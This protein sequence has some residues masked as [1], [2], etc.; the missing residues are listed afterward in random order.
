MWSI[1]NLM[2]RVSS[3][4]SYAVGNNHTI[5]NLMGRLSPSHIAMQLVTSSESLILWGVWVFL[6]NQAA[7]NEAQILNL[8]FVQPPNFPNHHDRVLFYHWHF[9]TSLLQIFTWRIDHLSCLCAFC[10]PTVNSLLK[11][12]K[13]TQAVCYKKKK[14][15]RALYWFV[16]VVYKI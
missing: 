14:G 10:L 11:C 8:W 12:F 3:L 15:K 16:L 2:E 1:L 6:W 7:S 9:L 5:L 4:H 13:N